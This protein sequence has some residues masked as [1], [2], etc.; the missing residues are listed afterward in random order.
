[1]SPITKCLKKGNFEWT[2]EV[3]GAFE[4]IKKKL[5][6]AHILALPDFNKVFEVECDASGVGIGAILTQD[7]RPLAYFSEKL[8]ESKK[9]CSTYDK[10]FYAIIRALD[11]W[12]RYLRPKQFVL[13]SDH[14]ALKFINGLHKL[15]SRHAKWVEFL[16][17][18][19][20]VSKYKQGSMNMVADALLRR[21]SILSILD[22]RVLGFSM[23]KEHHKQDEEIVVIITKC[24]K[25]QQARYASWEFLV[26]EV[27]GGGPV[28]HFG[29]TKTVEVL[30]EHFCWL[31]MLGDVQTIVARYGVCHRAKSH[32]KS[33]MYTP[34][35][36]PNQHWEDLS[37]DFIVVVLRTQR[38]KVSIMVVVD[39][40]SEMAHFIACN[41]TN[42][43]SHVVELFFKEIVKLHGVP[44]SI[45]LDRDTKFLSHFWRSLSVTT[46]DVQVNLDAKEKASSIK[47]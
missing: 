39:R 20:F 37:M 23:M 14:Q 13:H 4:V 18:F 33:G 15:N 28:G 21:C 11:H 19:S 31:K 16:Q 12:S 41:K 2:K 42:D 6:E 27:H 10:E 38:G 46:I 44:R 40:F 35:P 36:I 45:V 24:T 17:S 34:L 3:S 25:G 7:K 29:V 47:K 8:N 5:C 1:M 43:A 22:A 26:R 32:F 30:R 9:K